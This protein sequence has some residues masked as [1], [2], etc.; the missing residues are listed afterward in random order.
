MS[1]IETFYYDVD[2]FKRDIPDLE[3]FELGD[4]TSFYP[5]YGLRWR[6]FIIEGIRQGKRHH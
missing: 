6:P 1:K 3:E 4:L 5:T 2:D